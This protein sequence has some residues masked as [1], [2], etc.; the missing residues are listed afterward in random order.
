MPRFGTPPFSSISTS[1]TGRRPWSPKPLPVT[2]PCG[3]TNVVQSPGSRN[4]LY[5]YRKISLWQDSRHAAHHTYGGDTPHRSTHYA[6]PKHS[7]LSLN[8]HDEYFPIKINNCLPLS[9]PPGIN[10]GLSM[11]VPGTWRRLSTRCSS[12][13]HSTVVG[14]AWRPPGDCAVVSAL[15]NAGYTIVRGAWD[16]QGLVD[17]QPFAFHLEHGTSPG[18]QCLMR[19]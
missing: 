18:L 11:G 14:A 4:G 19:C 12:P 10:N 6:I 7:A 16:L 15:D 17:V 9:W 8:Q 5:L 1:G 3:L 13:P 2:P